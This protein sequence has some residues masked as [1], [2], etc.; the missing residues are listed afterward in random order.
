MKHLQ[1]VQDETEEWRNRNFPGFTA[2]DQLLGVV[3]E[4]G[5]L[6]HCYLKGKQGIRGTAE[7]HELNGMDAVGDIVIYLLG[8]C[9][10]I[11]LR[12]EDCHPYPKAKRPTPEPS[13]A[14]FH[15]AN[16]VGRLSRWEAD[17]RGS[18]Q[19]F[20]VKTRVI[21]EIIQALTV[22]CYSR[23]WDFNQCVLQAW[24]EVKDRDWV[25]N[26]QDGTTT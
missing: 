3:E 23:G 15:L 24:T 26:I 12:V 1:K 16:R 13:Q 14:I 2:S 10:A 4:V 25:K 21:G 7:A 18:T 5:E 20:Q 9:Q 8:Y 17:T 22:Y 6:S 19:W 11:G